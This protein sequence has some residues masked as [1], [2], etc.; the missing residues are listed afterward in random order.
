MTES[1]QPWALA[2]QA[3]TLLAIDPSGLSGLWVVARAGPVRDT[4]CAGIAT[5][6]TAHRRIHPGLGDE[7]LFGGVDLSAT[8]AEGRLVRS[9][10]IL[11]APA[12]LTLTMAERCPPG[13]AARLGQALDGPVGHALVALDEAVEEGE[14]LPQ[15]LADRLAFRVDLGA[16]GFHAAHGFAVDAAEVAEAQDMLV[17]VTVSAASLEQL[18]A[19]ALQFGINGLRAPLLALRAA[20]ANAA[21]LQRDTVTLEDLTLAAQLVFAHR[22]TRLPDDAA[23]HEPAPDEAP[24]DENQ[25]QEQ[26]Q[27]VMPDIP[28]EMLLEAVKAILPDSLLAQLATGQSSRMA[29]GASGTGARHRGNRRG[30]PLPPRPGKLHSSSRIDIPATLRAA[31][32]WQAVRRRTAPVDRPMQFRPTDIRLKRFEERSDRLLVFTVDASGSAALSRLAEAK[33]AIELLLAEAYSRR[34]HVALVSFRGETA[35]LLL[36]PTRSLVQTKRR[37]AGLPGGGGTPLAS[38]LKTALEMCI[39]AKGRG[40]TPTLAVLTDGRGNIALDGTAGRIQAGADATRIAR[41]VRSEGLPAVVIDTSRRPHP[42]LAA[43]A[44][45]MAAR[46]APLPRADAERLSTTLSAQLER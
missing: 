19:L 29:K 15:S 34:D 27:G 10:G 3:L 40:M 5:L 43:L 38:G 30:R 32:P 33:G 18:V 22:A 9:G 42:D 36:P 8:L 20:R 4:L 39:A 16:I 23:D 26:D 25:G 1:S 41:A 46:Y 28:Q 21:R 7:A 31:A 2:R 44:G 37:L 14:G 24:N 13:L 12:T 45:V 17:K 35:E 6:P 11:E